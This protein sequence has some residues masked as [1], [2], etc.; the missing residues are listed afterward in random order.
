VLCCAAAQLALLRNVLLLRDEDAPN[1]Y[2]P[3]CAPILRL[4]LARYLI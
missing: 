3:R 1:A 2:H 4:Y